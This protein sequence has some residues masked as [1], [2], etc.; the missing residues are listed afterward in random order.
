[1]QLAQGRVSHTLVSEPPYR[2][3]R[4]I[5]AEAP[6]VGTILIVAGDDPSASLLDCLADQRAF[7]WC[8][9][10]I[11][12]SELV[13]EP[14]GVRALEPR[15]GLTALVPSHSGDV[16]DLA[17]MAAAAIR[18][19]PAP[20]PT[21]LAWYVES[22]VGVEGISR[23]LACCFDARARAAEACDSQRAMSRSTVARSIRKL[24]TPTPREW[25]A[26]GELA[27]APRPG[28]FKSL[29][30]LALAIELDPRT[31]RRRVTGLLGWDVRSYAETAGWEPV[32]ERAL[33]LHCRM[34]VA[35]TAYRREA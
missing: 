25:S 18:A 33:R 32:L 20:D 28:H 30:A 3:A 24:G 5:G 26:L 13:R 11:A 12:C 27:A 2:S 10:C 8:P 14:H 35:P 9:A 4:L 6:P 7:P 22:R 29:E 16:G 21:T 19:R 23:S 31:L 34:G 15:P 17:A 1:M